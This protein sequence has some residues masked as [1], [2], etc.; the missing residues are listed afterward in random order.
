MENKMTGI[1]MPELVLYEFCKMVQRIVIED[2]HA[3]ED[4]TKTMLYYLFGKDLLENDIKLE[5]FNYFDQAKQIIIYD[6]FNVGIGYNSELA[7]MGCIHILLPSET[8][9]GS[10]I[11]G[12]E[13]YQ[14]YL[15]ETEE[16]DE[17]ED[18]LVHVTP[19]FTRSFDSSYSLLISSK[20]SLQAVV[21]YQF[22]K[23][24]FISLHEHL[25]LYGLQ[26]IKIGGS[27]IS[28]DSAFIPTSVYHR[29][30]TLGFSYE[31]SIA[32]MFK[33]KLAKNF[34]LTGMILE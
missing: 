32:R 12:N 14:D 8:S 21:I 15:E 7:E 24:C 31:V 10:P 25:E 23:A 33:E 17:G 2:F 20:N 16:V 22:M 9:D 5:T 19:V 26:N 6:K 3:H 27:D 34:K 30:L 18:E 28:M 13:N 4:E 11:G 29:S 1:N